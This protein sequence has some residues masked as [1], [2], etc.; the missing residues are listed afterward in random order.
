MLFRPQVS[1]EVVAVSTVPLPL[2]QPLAHLYRARSLLR[3]G[4]TLAPCPPRACSVPG[5]RPTQA[6]TCNCTRL[7]CGLILE[8]AVRGS[9]HLLM[10]SF[11]IRRTPGT[12]LPM[13]SRQI[14]TR[15]MLMGNRQVLGLSAARRFS[16][17]HATPF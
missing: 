7:G 14:V 13:P 12:I 17:I 3:N 5:C 15:F 2:L 1:L 16:L 8:T 9:T 6:L 11:L 4:R 10:L